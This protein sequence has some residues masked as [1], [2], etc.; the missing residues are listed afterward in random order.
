[1]LGGEL[2]PAAGD[3]RQARDL[4]DDCGEAGGPQPFF[5]GPQHVFV[6]RCRDGDEACRVEA[7]REKA[8]PIQIR[9]L[10]APQYGP[11][12]EAGEEAG[13]KAA[14][15][16][17][18]LFVAASAEEFVHRAQGETAARQSI[19]DQ[20]DTERQDAAAYRLLDVPDALAQGG[21]TG[22]TRHAGLKLGLL[23][24]RKAHPL[25]CNCRFFAGSRMSRGRADPSGADCEDAK[26]W[27]SVTCLGKHL[28]TLRVLILFSY[29]PLS[30]P[31]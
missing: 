26:D 12:T 8:R 20:R 9:P 16:G 23:Q 1:M 24:M 13:D 27:P 6:P 3:E 5:D 17:A 30:R 22:R 15:G 2:Q 19:V 11:R 18:V 29:L 31:R 10:Q 25:T 14:S 4:A 7:V 28:P 21:E